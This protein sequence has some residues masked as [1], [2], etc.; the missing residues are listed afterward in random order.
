MTDFIVTDDVSFVVLSTADSR[1][2]VTAAL[3]S[4]NLDNLQ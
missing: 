1:L 2:C 4:R 3:I